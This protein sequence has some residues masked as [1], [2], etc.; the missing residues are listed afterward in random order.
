V[1]QYRHITLAI[2]AHAYLSATAE[3]GSAAGTDLLIALT[4]PELRRLLNTL[5]RTPRPDLDHTADWSSWRQ[6]RQAQA[7]AAHY[8][9][10]G[11]APP[12]DLV[13]RAPRV[14]GHRRDRRPHRR[15]KH[16][17]Q[18]REPGAGHSAAAQLT[19]TGYGCAAPGAGCQREIGHCC[20]KLNSP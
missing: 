15:H 8:R 4:V 5:I 7:R 14:P 11:Q 1:Q 19:A 16:A 6:R 2:L 12:Y 9:R 10:R 17:D 20:A 3:K 13:A 18:A